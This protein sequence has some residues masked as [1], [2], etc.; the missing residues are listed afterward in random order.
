[1]IIFVL[2]EGSL[3]LKRHKYLE[4][5]SLIIERYPVYIFDMSVIELTQIETKKKNSLMIVEILDS[6]F[7][8]PNI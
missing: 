5:L 7:V 3:V 6:E 1:M 8:C 2:C 4:E